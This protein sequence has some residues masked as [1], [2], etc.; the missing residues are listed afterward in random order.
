MSQFSNTP[1]AVVG[2]ACQ[3]PSADG[4]DAYWDM[5]KSGRCTQAEIPPE[6]FNRRLYYDPNKGVLCKSYTSI[7][8]LMDYKP[9]DPRRCPLSPEDIATSDV[10]HLTI[11]D[12]AAEA[13]RHA[14][15]DPFAM[16][17]RENV[18]VYVGHVKAS[19]LGGEICFANQIEQVAE[20][21]LEVEQVNQITGGRTRGV[22]DNIVAQV[23]AARSEH[24]SRR[25]LNL[26]PHRGASLISKMLK[27][28]GPNMV[29]NAAC[30][31]SLQALAM[32]ARALQLGQ[33]DLAVVG[34]AS[35]CKFDSLVL[36][37]RA[38]SVSATGTRPFDADADGLVNGEG[39][40]TLL[41]KTL[42]RALA[43]KDQIHALVRGIGISTDGHGKSLWAPRK[44]GQ[45]EAI[46]RA[47]GSDIDISR[48]QFIEAH[49]TSTQV[50]DQTELQSLAETLEGKLPAGTRIP[51]GSVKGNVGHTI[52][53]AGMAGLLKTIL[54]MNHGTVP[55]TP[56][57]RQLNPKIDWD[58][59]P[60]FVPTRPIEWPRHPDGHARRAA[61]NSFGI[62]GLNVHVVMDDFL[63]K[64][65]TSVSVPRTVRQACEPVA[66]IGLG[67][68]L[69]GART[70]E[71]FWDMLN[72]GREALSALPAERW[73]EDVARRTGRNLSEQS[74]IR[75]GFVTDFA[76][77]W[78]KHRIPPK[79]LATADP[80]QFMLLDAVEQAMTMAGYD[81]K[82]FDRMRTGVCV[83][84]MSSGEYHE[85]LQM[86]L[87]LP[88]FKER[89]AAAL[90]EFGLA[91]DQ[92]DAI[93]ELYQEA[94]IRHMPS[95]IDETGSYTTNTLVSRIT[96]AYDLMGGGAAI[97]SGDTS[98]FSAL[99]AAINILQAGDC[100]MMICAAGHR[101]MGLLSYE[102]HAHHGLLPSGSPRSPFDANADGYHPGE[103]TGAIVL[104]RL[105]DAQRD[106][107]PIHGVIRGFGASSSEAT[108]QSVRNAM[109][110]GREHAGLSGEPMSFVESAA[111]GTSDDE[112]EL[113]AIAE[114]AGSPSRPVVIGS[115][116]NQVGHTGGLSGLV[117]ILKT[118][119]ALSELSAP[120]N[121]NLDQAS[122]I[123][124]RHANVLHAPTDATPLAASTDDGR[125]LAGVNSSSDEKLTYHFVVERG[126]PVRQAVTSPSA[127]T[128][129]LQGSG[130]L[131]RDEYLGSFRI[132]R[133]G[134]ANHQA[135]A[136][137]VAQL[138]ESTSHAEQMF[139]TANHMY[140][141]PADRLRFAVVV[142]DAAELQK[143]C[144]LAAPLLDRPES[145]TVL[146]DRGVFFQE[147]LATPQIAFL[148][149]GHGSQYEG[150]LQSLLEN[151]APAADAMRHVDEI[152][153]RLRFP[154]FHEVAWE[155]GDTL[156]TDVWQTQLAL[157]CADTIMLAAIQALDIRPDHVAGHSFGEFPALIAAGAWTFENAARATYARCQAIENGC[158]IPGIMLSVAAE[159][160]VLDEVAADIRR[161]L[162]ISVRNASD[163]IVVGGEEQ[164]VRELAQRLQQ[165]DI[166]TRVLAAPR[167][168]H[169]PL[170]EGSKAPL[171]EALDEI[172]ILPPRVSMLSSVTNRYV[173]EPDTIRQNLVAQMTDPVHYDALIE[174]LV[175]HGVQ[176]IVEV[177][178][179]QILTKLHRRI[180]AGH[181][182]V[183]IGA[184]QPKRSGLR[185]IL[186]VRACLECVGA[187]EQ[188]SN[189]VP[190]IFR[191]S[192]G[193]T[194][195]EW[196]TKAERDQEVPARLMPVGH[197]QAVSTAAT[198]SVPNTGDLPAATDVAL[199]E[200]S[201]PLIELRGTP[202]DMGRQCGQA[203][204][205]EIR[206]LLRHYADLAG[207]RYHR[208]PDIGA[209]LT[210]AER[211][212]PEEDMLELQGI[213]D[214]AGVLLDSVV[215]HNL[216]LYPDEGS[217]CVQ[218]AVTAAQ[219]DGIGLIHAANEDL[220]LSLTLGNRL[221]RNVQ[222]RR[223]DGKLAHLIFGI[224]GELAGINGMNAAG[225]AVTSTMLLDLPRRDETRDG[226]AHSGI[227]K[228]ILESADSVD[229]AIEIAGQHAG[230]GGWSLCVS[231]HQTDEV[232]YLEYDGQRLQTQRSLLRHLGANHCQ[233]HR[234]TTPAPSHS[235]HRL[236]RLTA[237]IEES[238]AHT[239]TV[240]N[241][242]S[243]LRDRFDV[244]RG[245]K[246]RFPTMNTI[247][248]VDNQVSLVMQPAAGRAW[249]TSPAK[250]DSLAEMYHEINVAALLGQP[251]D[252]AR[253]RQTKPVTT[254]AARP[255]PDQGKLPSLLHGEQAE[256]AL[257]DY[258]IGPASR[259][260]NVC[261]RFVMRTVAT[262]D[263]TSQP[264]RLAGPVVILGQNSVSQSLRR[265]LEQAGATVNV[266]P[267]L[268]DVD[269]ALADVDRIFQQAPAPHLF[270][271]TPYDQ[272]ADTTI[273][274]RDWQQ[275]RRR[276]ASVPYFVCQR[277]C[278]HLLEADLLEQSTVVAATVMGGDF[279]FS[280]TVRSAESGA[281]TGLVKSLHIELGM[282]TKGKFSAKIIDVAQSA[283]AEEVIDSIY[284][285]ITSDSKEVEI[286]YADGQRLVVRPIV[287]AVRD[288][289][290]EEDIPRGG[291]W[292]VTGGA[293]GVTAIVAR[294]L[295]QRYGLKL[296]LVG[297]SPLP[298]IEP[299]WRNMT[300][301]QEKSLRAQVMKEA[302]TRKEVPVAAWNKVEKAIE[303]DRNLAAFREAGVQF[304][305][306][307]C[308]IS[309]WSALSR[310]LD[311]I[312]R[313][314]GT[315]DGVVH[316]AGFES[317]LRFEKKK[318]DLVERTIAV[319]VDGAAA[320][321]D[322]TRQDPLR[323]FLAF[324][325]VSGRFGGLGQTDYGMA[326]DMLCKLVDWFRLLRPECKSTCFH[327]HAWD[328]V[329]MAVRPESR[330]LREIG[331]ITYMPTLEG[332][333][334]L[335][336]E[337]RAGAPEREVLI[338]GWPFH[339]LNPEYASKVSGASGAKS[340]TARETLATKPMSVRTVS[341]P[342]A[343]GTRPLSAPE[344]ASS[345]TMTLEP[346]IEPAIGNLPLADRVIEWETGQRI[347]CET[348]MDPT[349]DPF[350]IQHLY[351][352]RPILPAVISMSAVAQAASLLGAPG[353][354]VSAIR[355]VELLEPMRFYTDR[356]AEVRVT[357]DAT[358]AGIECVVSSDFF[359]RT[360]KLVQANRP[361]MRAI[362]DLD[363]PTD[364]NRLEAP[365]P[366][367]PEDPEPFSDFNYPDDVVLF[368]GD[369]FRALKEIAVENDH[370]WGRIRALDPVYLGGSRT[371]SQWWIPASAIDAAFYT[372][373]VHVRETIRG[374]AKIPKSLGRLRIG[375]NIRSGERLLAVATC[376]KLDESNATYDFTIFG[377]DGSVVLMVEDYYGVF[378]PRGE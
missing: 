350:L 279:G 5:L 184:D 138:G 271:L 96:K 28:D 115:T 366:P 317:A 53:T 210:N 145:R 159:P 269:A 224:A 299:S 268:D 231:H 370:A 8:C 64:T 211:Y 182:V 282:K 110:R 276:G 62:G 131:L 261:F 76:Y 248:R 6:R 69:P 267:A 117:S 287:Q 183:L 213:A 1:L 88:E 272:D 201:M 128:T 359:T 197:D 238:A 294:E 74:A 339:K 89:L 196:V 32:A 257:Q 205:A 198:T 114:T 49:A 43:D 172:E 329:G 319:K 206:A 143:K 174:R 243:A 376:R 249:I 190:D 130:S 29:V 365:P 275:R 56:N 199:R 18:G 121:V 151:F 208:L 325:S 125:V 229:Q 176:V 265:R 321:M 227:V 322:L 360:G 303:I 220:P 333:N 256:Q 343:T 301:D 216:M 48:L 254:A 83:G 246:T 334:H 99:A 222:I 82:E 136:E 22:I 241:A 38:Q 68:V 77:D 103:G 148:F 288:L 304:T 337:V 289:P 147:L 142:E 187:W 21:L 263:P 338:T 118:T 274:A 27:L 298:A 330:H 244:A 302:V 120:A 72:N 98:A 378:V 102:L 354:Q 23:R 237:V 252:V 108:R 105:V 55:P 259:N 111:R 270:L 193:G 355:N 57:L 345:A 212:F 236:S 37:S 207:S 36:F 281:L 127:E 292:V 358:E 163:Q 247:R 152:L 349:A 195:T 132:V 94:L 309:N 52:E 368:H 332:T 95:I 47:Y 348:H 67:A 364:E 255:A 3:M 284:R 173:A 84:A 31:S 335:I 225:L 61:V 260:G 90:Q 71:A 313:A 107:D 242:Q 262:K 2:M 295:G 134:A 273:D 297:S 290:L 139:S 305:Y 160:Q 86:G 179:H 157:L 4:L 185:Q 186:H 73:S 122:P 24:L 264:L 278:Q 30:A 63:P 149:P 189:R 85:T 60:F 228:A 202:Y 347:V 7:A 65:S 75:G 251:T 14:G 188:P 200:T 97:D 104:K 101:A 308:D 9:V 356:V 165:R 178:P 140:F 320:L 344:T 234:G 168:F 373:G 150:M 300:P 283:T 180:L 277:W 361:Y 353:E 58:N 166:V 50:G 112:Q 116:T 367:E 245:R 35:Y 119:R 113:A 203:Q 311:E 310:V 336:N 141:Q 362:V 146:Q 328:E 12:V 123:I 286:G 296:H 80:L 169:T 78:K 221:T 161:E 59:S 191:H 26:S 133:V 92:L 171:A 15:Y 192:D 156:G 266:I 307:A 135:L 194:Q 306:Y 79:Q 91:A 153:Q 181:D 100:D 34:S 87:R 232:A 214:G 44:E 204:A 93:G 293:R 81:D 230:S 291:T 327:W 209:A 218:F 54:S 41:V 175:G 341:S 126:E 144:K 377:E 226:R 375:R 33:I 155:R 39:Y 258:G 312:R 170:M 318:R 217:G 223:P 326:N 351:K 162:H 124:T 215:A 137:Q 66:I 374:V 323:Y 164:P 315:I 40:V 235:Q 352:K 314:D 129:A 324:G 45:V 280:G 233:L 17:L 11:C 357:A 10:A 342:S 253:L 109:R 25:N 372:C 219:N 106:G 346:V 20:Y 13:C 158:R 331:G 363:S 154:S 16:P 42:D 177:G 316:G 167:A 19:E 70:I 371:G 250:S 239:L 240:E 46:R 369:V 285:E 340:A 51:I